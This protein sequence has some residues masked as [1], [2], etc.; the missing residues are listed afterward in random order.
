M[1]LR[2]PSQYPLKHAI[3]AASWSL[4]IVALP[5]GAIPK[6]VRRYSAAALPLFLER[7][8]FVR[9]HGSLS[10]RPPASRLTNVVGNYT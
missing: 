6:L 2:H 3:V 1:R 8:N 7:Y 5:D 9:P 4:G 10:H